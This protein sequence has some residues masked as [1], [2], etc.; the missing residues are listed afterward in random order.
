MTRCIEVVGH[1]PRQDTIE[2]PFETDGQETGSTGRC[3][4]SCSLWVHC[5]CEVCKRR[6][7]RGG[8]G[9][10]SGAEGE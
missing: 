1:A 7:G 9:G 8:E 4:C 3:R 10:L 6:A 5:G 2:T